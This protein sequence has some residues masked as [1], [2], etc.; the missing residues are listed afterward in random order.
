MTAVNMNC[1]K[2]MTAMKYDIGLVF[3]SAPW[4]E[5]IQGP[6]FNANGEVEIV[7]TFSKHDSTAQGF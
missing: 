5:N 4:I 6:N 2:A 1:S 7:S 3:R